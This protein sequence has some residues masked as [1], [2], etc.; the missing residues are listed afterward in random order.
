MQ[1][2]D[3]E[4]EVNQHGNA[5]PHARSNER[6]NE[7]KGYRERKYE[8]HLGALDHRIPMLSEGSYFPYC[9]QA[10]RMREKRLNGVIQEA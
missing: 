5:E 3:K 8:T 9:L 2:G 6:E 7:H 10:R 4:Q 1:K